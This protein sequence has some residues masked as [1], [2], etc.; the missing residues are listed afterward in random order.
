MSKSALVSIKKYVMQCGKVICCK[1]IQLICGLSKT[2]T[3]R[4]IKKLLE[5]GFVVPVS[6]TSSPTYYTYNPPSKRKKKSNPQKVIINGITLAIFRALYMQKM[7]E[8]ADWLHNN[9][10]LYNSRMC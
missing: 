1:D 8:V 3:H 7:R 9:R 2:T 6:G 4:N 10:S 5:E